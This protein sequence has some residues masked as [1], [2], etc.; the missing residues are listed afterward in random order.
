MANAASQRRQDLQHRA[1]LSAARLPGLMVAAQRIAANVTLGS[2]GRRRPGVGES[3][4]Q[5][6]P[7]GADDTPEMIDWRQSAKSDAIYVREREWVSAQTVNLWCDASP[8]MHYRSLKNLPTKAERAAT[9]TLALGILL[10]DG[11]ERIVR[12]APNGLRAPGA[13][14]GRLALTQMAEGLA[15][16]LGPETDAAFPQFGAGLAR[17]GT[18]VL[19]SDF[20]E[21]VA[22]LSDS[23]RSLAETTQQVHMVQVLDPVEETLPF[24]GRVR[25]EG[26]E[27][28]GAFVID[29][30]EDARREYQSK[31]R[32]HREAIRGIAQANGWS[33]AVHHTD[34][35]PHMTL[36]ALHRAV[37]ERRR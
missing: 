13:T 4:W 3:F 22:T 10:V 29:R 30:V 2:H 26:L 24:K 32:A 5:F 23:L 28:D 36:V 19:I 17:H 6:R 25:F 11:G 20:L 14:A 34:A 21:P 7:Y 8:S 15:A 31:V 27:D 33:F 35:P 16:S 12:L 1:E 9:L 18:T 37:G